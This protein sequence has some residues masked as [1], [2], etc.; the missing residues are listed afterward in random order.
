MFGAYGAP[1][2]IVDNVWIA[3]GPVNASLAW[4]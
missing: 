1:L 2:D 3:S 4:D